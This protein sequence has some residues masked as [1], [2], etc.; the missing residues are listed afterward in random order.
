MSFDTRSTG[1]EVLRGADLSSLRVLVTGAS[2]GLGLES[3]R[4]LAAHGAHVTL[5]V[6]DMGKSQAA[7]ET[8]RGATRDTDVALCE[9]DLSSL[10]AIRAQ[11]DAW[12]GEKKPFNLILANAG[13]M[14]CPFTHTKDGFEMQFGVNHLGHFLLANRLTPLLIANAPSRIVFISSGAHRRADIDLEDPN[15]EHS[16]YDP[17][18]AYGRS[19]T[20][21]ALMGVAF[22]ARLHDKG[23]RACSVSP[24]AVPETN[25][26]RHLSD[27]AM[28]RIRSST[29][30]R[31]VV[32]TLAEGVATQLWASAIASS[33]T[34][35]GRYCENCGI[36][37]TV[38]DPA[39]T[40]GVLPYAIDPMR[41]DALW[42][43]SE[44][45]VG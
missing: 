12:L 26:T 38:H 3:A 4:L 31:P 41:A 7:L 10:A 39:E 45:F 32:K 30:R 43:L 28:E 40:N 25:V 13:V 8:A 22:D 24:G 44:K 1:E 33:E 23:V 35:G 18:I 34:I 27:A 9:L 17:W 21:N 15:F 14:A 19:K 2:S 16:P 37:A 36:A 11:T 42:S 6:R 29:G 5:A 20:A